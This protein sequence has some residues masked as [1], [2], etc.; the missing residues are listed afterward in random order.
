MV[1]LAAFAILAVIEKAERGCV[2]E[3]LGD[4]GFGETVLGLFVGLPTAAVVASLIL[5][6]ARVRH[7]VCIAALGSSTASRRCS[8]PARRRSRINRSRC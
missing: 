4:C 2:P 8:S 5:F 6:I 7:A 3:L 1:G